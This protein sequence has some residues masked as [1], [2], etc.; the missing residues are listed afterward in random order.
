MRYK[1]CRHNKE[2]GWVHYPAD[3]DPGATATAYAEDYEL[4]NDDIVEVKSHG[5]FKISVVLEP[6]YYADKI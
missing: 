1:K 5:K 3:F 6:V 2:M 4:E